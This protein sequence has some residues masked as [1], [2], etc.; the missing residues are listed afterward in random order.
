MAF[1]PDAAAAM[2]GPLVI[3]G[4]QVTEAFR[5]WLA[6]RKWTTATR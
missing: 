2:S 6:T 4:S 5:F 1:A 3:A